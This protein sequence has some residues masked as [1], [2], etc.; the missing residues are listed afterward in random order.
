[1]TRLGVTVIEAKEIVQFVTAKSWST[2]GASC[3]LAFMG[4]CLIISHIYLLSKGVGPFKVVCMEGD[5]TV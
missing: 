4:N 5:A 3:H 2:R 1:M